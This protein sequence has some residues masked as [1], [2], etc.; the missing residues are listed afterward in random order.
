[1]RAEWPMTV[2]R[3]T[4][5]FVDIML[6][7]PIPFEVQGAARDRAHRVRAGMAFHWCLR[8]WRRH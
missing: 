8:E 7:T 2:H 6:D 5:G 1:M 4:L 3:A